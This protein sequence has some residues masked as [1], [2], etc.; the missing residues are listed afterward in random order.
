MAVCDYNTLL[1]DGRCFTTLPLPIQQAAAL[2]LWCSISGGI[3]P[4]PPGEG[5]GVWNPDSGG[6]PI[7]GD[8]GPIVNPDV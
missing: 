7:F 5:G 2:S 4:P 3:T 8:D 1:A 6:G